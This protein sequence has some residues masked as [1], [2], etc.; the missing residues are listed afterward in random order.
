MKQIRYLSTKE[1]VKNYKS[2]PL[3]PICKSYTSIKP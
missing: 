3:A 2:E 1:S